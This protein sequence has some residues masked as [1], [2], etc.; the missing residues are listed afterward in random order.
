ME[1]SLRNI[2]DPYKWSLETVELLRA[3]D[4]ARIDM[5]ELINEIGTLASGLRRELLSLL[6][7]ILEA[8]L[9]K[10]FVSADNE[11]AERQLVNAQGQLQLL[12][13]ASPS[14]TEALDD[15]VLKA[16]GRAKDYVAREYGVAILPDRCPFPIDRITEDPFDRMV[17]EG[18]FDEN[19]PA[20]S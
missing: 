18:K 5:D 16:Y 4:F 3:G 20:S 7:D 1:K 17:A 2:D 11:E 12:F 6:K 13:Y 9:I 8:L 19:V 14:L 10:D 15:S